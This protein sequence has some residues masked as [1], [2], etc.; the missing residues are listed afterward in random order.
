MHCIVNK[1]LLATQLSIQS[2]KHDAVIGLS[3]TDIEKT[4]GGEQ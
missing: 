2:H 4:E 1:L 3:A